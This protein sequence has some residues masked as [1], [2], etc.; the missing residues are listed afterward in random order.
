MISTIFRYATGAALILALTGCGLFRTDLPVR[1]GP[2][3]EPHVTY[4][5][6]E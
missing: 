4:I 2:Q 3:S 6:V 1:D 5:T